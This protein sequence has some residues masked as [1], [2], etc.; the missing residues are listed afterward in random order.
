[1]LPIEIFQ[2]VVYEN[3]LNVDEV[4]AVLGVDRERARRLV[5]GQQSNVLLD[6]VERLIAGLGQTPTCD[7]S[8]YLTDRG[9][10]R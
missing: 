8:R 3:G 10:S 2:R 9:D 6:T 1:M 7:I 5:K 4:A